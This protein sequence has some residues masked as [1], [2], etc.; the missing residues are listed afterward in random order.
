MQRKIMFIPTDNNVGLNSIILGFTHI[1]KNNKISFNLINPINQF[2]YSSKDSIEKIKKEF[3]IPRT[4]VKKS[5][6]MSR[7]EY[8]MFYKKQDVLI[9]E[10]ISFYYENIKNKKIT[11]IQGLIPNRHCYFINSL[12]YK[13]A[14]SL[15]AKIVFLTTPNK[16][17]S[18]LKLR[19]KINLLINSFVGL[20]KERIEGIII[21]KIN[22]FL[23][24][25]IQYNEKYYKKK[26]F[27]I[28]VLGLIPWNDYIYSIRVIDLCNYLN[29]NIINKGET[30]NKRIKS[31]IYCANK[32]CL[33]YLLP[34]NLLVIKSDEKK[35]INLIYLYIKNGNKI[36]GILIIRK[37]SLKNKNLY[38][39][40]IKTKV[41]VF[42]INKYSSNFFNLEKIYLFIQ[43]NNIEKI[44]KIKQYFSSK[45]YS[46]WIKN[47]YKEKKIKEK[48]LPD[49]FLYKL[50]HLTQKYKKKIILPEGHD[51]R[52]INAAY[53]CAQ[54]N[55]TKCILLGNA[56]KI[57]SKIKQEG[58]KIHSNIR[59]IDAD[60]IRLNYVKRLVE[61]RKNKNITEKKAQ[62]YLKNNIV[63]ATMILENNEVDGLVSGI[64]HTTADT[65]RPA[66]QIIK[67]AP[68]NSII[69]S[70]FFMLT[71]NKVLI[72]ADCAI[73]ISPNP[74]QLAEIA[75]QSSNLAKLFKIKPKIAMISYS[76]G[77]SGKGKEVEKV[78]QATKIVKSIKPDLIIDGPIQYDAAT[79]PKIALLKSNCSTLLGEANIIIFP[80][81]NTGNTTYK[82]VQHTSNIISIGP[83]LQGIR[84]P[85]NDLSRGAS[86]KDIV[87]TILVTSVQSLKNV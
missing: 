80:D 18:N 28:K 41:T 37:N 33:N 29:G 45:I 17:S 2:K 43:K 38:K 20:K 16:K 30:Y 21:N 67:T 64:T 61:I 22:Y 10:I 14:I 44:K 75:I 70:A 58:L 62:E 72:Y 1:M 73:N 71:S 69:S 24:K 53:I 66:L 79:V 4:P 60:S 35:L 63:L 8:L 9:E 87:Y 39:I 84:K 34:N 3:F 48:I 54:R 27:N 13:I 23:F 86:I 42:K 50:I 7:V 82:A 83:I 59:I 78:A 49:F 32:L 31:I 40:F 47:L 6:L 65:I 68:K 11:I 19:K 5:I 46:S 57:Y 85:V 26:M 25:N 52:I 15:D 51:L 77:N 56:N 55:T 76:T 74:E 12:N 36:A 81:L